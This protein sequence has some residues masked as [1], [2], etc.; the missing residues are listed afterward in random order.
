MTRPDR[1]EAERAVDTLL[2]WIGEDPARDGLRRT[3]ARVVEAW[4]EH[5]SGYRTTPAEALGDLFDEIETVDEI[6]LLRDI[7]FE[8][9]CEHHLAPIV[10]RAHVAYL[11]GK[12][13]VGI[14]RLARL[15]DCLAKRLQVQERLTAEIAEAIQEI[16]APRGVAVM[17]QATHHCMTTR[18]VHKPGAVMVTSRLLGAFRTDRELRRD[19]YAM[20]GQPGVDAIARA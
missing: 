8:S 18:G 14:G 13:V 7:G 20:I 6:V 19:F 5:A 4:L 2:R 12:K 1:E 17:I 3:P 11:P 15:V 9:H 10:G 16:L